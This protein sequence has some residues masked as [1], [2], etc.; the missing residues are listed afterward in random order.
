[1]QDLHALSLQELEENFV[2]EIEGWLWNTEIA[3]VTEKEKELRPV[4]QKEL[5]ELLKKFPE[6]F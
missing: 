5:A 2:R 1:M 6:V 3:I 4:Q